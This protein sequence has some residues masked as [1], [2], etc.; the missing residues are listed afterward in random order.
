MN[1]F[2]DRLAEA[3]VLIADGA[4]GTMLQD[5]GVPP[6]SLNLDRPDVVRKLH[7]DYIAAGAELILTNTFAGSRPQLERMGLGDKLRRINLAAARLARETAGD[8]A[9]VLGD[10]GPTGQ[11]LRPLGKL[12]YKE[13]V[14]AFAEQATPLAEGAVD[15]IL[16]ETMSDLDEIKA[17]IEG[18]RR[19]SDL[20]I[21]A[22]MSFDTH[23]HTMMGVRPDIAAVELSRL[24]VTAIGAN[25]GH[26]L[27]DNLQAIQQMRAAAPAAVLLAKPNAGLPKMKM[28]NTVYSVTPQEMADYARRFVSFGVKIFGGCCGTT[29][30]HIRAIA[31]ALR[32][33]HQKSD[34]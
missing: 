10:I 2:E 33:G 29:P 9:L 34:E 5:V 30:G 32:N 18:V 3:D 21:I 27:N 12:S 28:G 14:S 8:K 20:P 23:V 4:T 13:A 15:A 7:Q 24:E 17:A 22:S 25:C 1:R 26:T 16:I 31:A 6:V 19:A 11:L